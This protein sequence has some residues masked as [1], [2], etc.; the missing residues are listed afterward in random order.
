MKYSIEEGEI[1]ICC[2]YLIPFNKGWIDVRWMEMENA[3]KTTLTNMARRAV[4][5]LNNTAS[6]F[7]A[8]PSTVEAASLP[9]AAAFGFI[10]GVMLGLKRG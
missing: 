8:H 4:H 5:V 6:Q 9:V 10:P 3:T 2:W 1:I 7:A